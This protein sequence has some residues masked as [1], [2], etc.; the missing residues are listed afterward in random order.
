MEPSETA[1]DL[2]R[3]R[4]MRRSGFRQVTYIIIM[5]S[6]SC[7]SQVNAQA[8]TL[9]L[10]S[11][12]ELDSLPG[13]FSPTSEV[14][15]LDD[16]GVESFVMDSVSQGLPDERMDDLYLLI[17]ARGTMVIPLLEGELHR[18]LRTDAEAQELS[19]RRMLDAIAYAG[20]EDG[21]AALAKLESLSPKAVQ[22]YTEKLLS[23]A[24]SSR[25]PFELAYVA[26]AQDHAGSVSQ[27]LRSWIR[28]TTED[29][30]AW[31]EWADAIERRMGNREV[32]SED[33]LVEVVY[34]GVP[35]IELLDELRG[36]RIP[37]ERE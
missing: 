32:F 16:G 15:G 3:G 9:P 4:Q 25:N 28:R 31:A 8:G 11:G 34:G 1:A 7:S 26:S 5:G 20:N 13:S 29:S 27:G 12:D 6:I 19:T 37:T 14:V 22:V 33:P 23:H 17:R 35:P 21:L 36:R 2:E 18:A 30:H 24:R 10:S